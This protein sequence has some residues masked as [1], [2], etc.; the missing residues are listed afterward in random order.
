MTGRNKK[1]HLPGYQQNAL[2]KNESKN[3]AFLIES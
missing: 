1:K 2:E 3:K